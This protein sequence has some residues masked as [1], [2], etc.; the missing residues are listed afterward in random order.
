DRH[1]FLHE[2]RRLLGRAHTVDQRLHGRQDLALV[3]LA[4]DAPRAAEQLAKVGDVA[5]VQLEREPEALRH[6]NLRPPG[7]P[8][9]AAD[10]ISTARARST[11]P[12]VGPRR[13]PS[14]RAAPR[15]GW[16]PARRPL[17]A[18]RRS[19]PRRRP[20]ARAAAG[21]RARWRPARGPAAGS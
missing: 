21:P 12:G 5:F 16:F 18:A 3:L 10:S 2:A 19:A 11:D 14:S 17:R 4:G 8:A 20:A 6:R 1:G 15:R 13:L 9:A 7:R